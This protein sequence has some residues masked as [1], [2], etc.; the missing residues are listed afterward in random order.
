LTTIPGPQRQPP[1]AAAG[2]SP[3]GRDFAAKYA[4]TMLAACINIDDMKELRKDMHARLQSYGRDPAKFKMLYICMPVFGDSR[5]DAL[6]KKEEAKKARWSDAAVEYSLWYMSY[7]SGGRIDFSKFDLDKPVSDLMI[8]GGNGERVSMS[9]MFKDRGDAT[10]REIAATRFSLSDLDMIGTHEMVADR[11]D[12][13]MAE[14]GGDGFLFYQPT[15]RRAIIEISDGLAP[16]LQA[17]G[18]VR[19]TYDYPTLKENLFAF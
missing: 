18:S 6:A 8:S 5:E 1:I 19:K 17:R 15:T 12:E 4:D 16:V 13:I 10:L 9:N 7:V 14:V 11:M 3:A 2:N